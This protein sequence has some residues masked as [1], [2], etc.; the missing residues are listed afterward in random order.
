MFH[1]GDMTHAHV[2]VALVHAHV[3]VI[4]GTCA[5]GHGHVA[6]TPLAGYELGYM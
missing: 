4:Q 6:A 3:D 5:H 2:H 1:A